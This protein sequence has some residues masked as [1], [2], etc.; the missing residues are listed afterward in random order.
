M[1]VG[2][3]KAESEARPAGNEGIGNVCVKGVLASVLRGMPRCLTD[4]PAAWKVMPVAWSWPTRGDAHAAG[5]ACAA[6]WLPSHQPAGLLLEAS[7]T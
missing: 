6:A 2:S 4:V 7:F 1:K 5:L 3:A